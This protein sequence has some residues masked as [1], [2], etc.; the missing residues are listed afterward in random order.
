MEEFD[1][2]S[3]DN[4]AQDLMDIKETARIKKIISQLQMYD[5]DPKELT[6]I[7]TDIL[8]EDNVSFILTKI[9]QDKIFVKHFPEFYEKNEFGEN[10]LNCQ[11]NSDYHKY[12]VFKHILYNSL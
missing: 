12:G 1:F 10:V 8:E 2:M 9:S 11:Q 4:I 3:T 7:Y 5:N 6:R